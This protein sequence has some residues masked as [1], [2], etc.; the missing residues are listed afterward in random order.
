MSRSR[1]S[2]SSSNSRSSSS[3]PG[4]KKKRSKDRPPSFKYMITEAIWE[5]RK[6][7]KG[8]SRADIR[9]FI[10]NNYDVDEDKLKTNLSSTLSK[11]L[12]EGNDGYACLNKKEAN[13]RLNTEW[14]KEWTKKYGKKST[15]R[16]KKVKR[17]K[18]QPKHPKNG[19]MFYI[20]DVR[21][22]RR[23]EYPEL[24]MTDLT[25]KIAE[26][27]RDLASKRKSKY[28]DM[29]AED[30]ERY[31]KEMKGYKKLKKSDSVSESGSEESG[32]K[33]KRR[34]PSE[35][36]SESSKPKKK[37]RRSY[38]S[39]SEETKKE[40]PKKKVATPSKKT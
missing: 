31:H 13:Y 5:D 28:Q 17:D 26:E 10:M 3:S 7:T 9:K 24:S 8:S 32:S 40:A 23:E 36:G 15:V 12:Q 4:P 1:R 33:R 34:V 29:A 22:R 27:W 19:Y 21:K 37:R 11:M 39:S 6:W 38:S 14:R 25:K 20:Q 35:S 2:S 18:D 30:R 16:R